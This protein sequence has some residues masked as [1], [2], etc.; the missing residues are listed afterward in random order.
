MYTCGLCCLLLGVLI[1]VYTAGPISARAAFAESQG[2]TDTDLVK[3][4]ELQRS[5][6]D[7]QHSSRALRKRAGRL[8]QV[9]DNVNVTSRLRTGYSILRSTGASFLAPLSIGAQ[10]FMHV[11][12]TGSADTW[13]VSSSFTCLDMV[14]RKSIPQQKCYF[15]PTYTTD[16]TFQ[17]IQNQNFNITYGDGEFLTGILG[18]TE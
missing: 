2:N 13:V 17:Q 3:V 11:L 7:L 8:A 14:S 12:D 18:N 16:S 1:S 10:S 4:V 15:G 9:E 6:H 5:H